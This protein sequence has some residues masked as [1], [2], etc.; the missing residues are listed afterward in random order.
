MA[1]S[2]SW[3]ARRSIPARTGVLH[4]LVPRPLEVADPQVRLL[5]DLIG[6]LPHRVQGLLGPASCVLDRLGGAHTGAGSRLGE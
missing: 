6:A 1:V 2:G 3:T 4:V 5:L